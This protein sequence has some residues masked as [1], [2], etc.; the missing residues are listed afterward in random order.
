MN[1]NYIWRKI[2]PVI[3]TQFRTAIYTINNR[4]KHYDFNLETDFDFIQIELTAEE[5][6][7]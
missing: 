5:P 6:I 4:V 7:K 3:P 1:G 2:A